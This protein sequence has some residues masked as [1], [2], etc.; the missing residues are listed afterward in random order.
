MIDVRADS[1]RVDDARDS[2]LLKRCS[3]SLPCNRL[4][5]STCV[6]ILRY[7]VTYAT[8]L[9][10]RSFWSCWQ[11]QQQQQQQQQHRYVETTAINAAFVSYE[12]LYTDPRYEKKASTF[13]LIAVCTRAV[14]YQAVDK[15]AD[16]VR[17]LLF[18]PLLVAFSPCQPPLFAP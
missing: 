15:R 3:S 4:V 1:S 18:W 11:Q 9:S 10:S 13:H 2:F 7:P 6:P 12:V 16:A 8:T 17:A 5:R 14:I